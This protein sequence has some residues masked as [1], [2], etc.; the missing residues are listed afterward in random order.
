M[1]ALVFGGIGGSLLKKAVDRVSAAKKANEED[2]VNSKPKT[3]EE[4]K[5][6]LRTRASFLQTSTQGVLGSAKT[7]RTKLLGN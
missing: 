2:S 1:A 6:L 7:G 3:E 5:A 4:K